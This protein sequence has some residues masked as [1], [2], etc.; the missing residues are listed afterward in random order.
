[1]VKAWG[2]HSCVHG[3]FQTDVEFSVACR[4]GFQPL[5]EKRLEAAST[6]GKMP[7]LPDMRFFI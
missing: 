4:S 7:A 3:A 5:I 1:M 6:V 2:R